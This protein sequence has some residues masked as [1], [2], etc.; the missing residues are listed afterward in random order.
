MAHMCHKINKVVINNLNKSFKTRNLQPGLGLVHV[1][2][3]DKQI[4]RL[5]DYIHT[6]FVFLFFREYFTHIMTSSLQVKGC[7]IMFSGY[8]L[9]TGSD[10][11][12]AVQLL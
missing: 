7:E 10:F 3:Y 1:H 4:Q 2:V 9:L 6:V 11:Y 12:R 8:G 5:I